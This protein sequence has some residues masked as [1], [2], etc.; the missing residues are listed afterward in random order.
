MQQQWQ[1]VKVE[2]SDEAYVQTNDHLS[3]QLGGEEIYV[4]KGTLVLALS[5]RLGKEDKL[6]VEESVAQL[7]PV[8]AS[9][10]EKIKKN[11]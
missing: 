6:R 4:R 5:Y 9:I 11:E 7:E 2:K 1:S 3:L 8:I 10:L